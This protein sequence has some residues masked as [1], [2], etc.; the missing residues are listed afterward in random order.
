MGLTMVDSIDTMYLMGLKD[1]YKKAR[2]WIEKN[3]RFDNNVIILFIYIYLI[4]FTIYY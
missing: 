4:Y 3:L 1:E 2:D